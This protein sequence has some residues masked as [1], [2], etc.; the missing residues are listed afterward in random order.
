[1]GLKRI[2]SFVIIL[3]FLT[4][5]LIYFRQRNPAVPTLR[6]CTWS[7]YFPESAIKSF[8]DTTGI[9]VEIS[10]ISSNEELFAKLKAG[11]TGFD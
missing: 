2:I 6:V 3:G 7:N 11:A 4:G 1:M 8:V 5:I 10:Y 9:K